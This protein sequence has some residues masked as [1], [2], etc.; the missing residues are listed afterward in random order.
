M[1]SKE[2]IKQYEEI[3]GHSIYGPSGMARI[4]RCPASVSEALRAPLQRSSS[5][6]EHGTKLHNIIAAATEDPPETPTSL[7]SVIS[8]LTRTIRCYCTT[9][10]TTTTASS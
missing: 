9:R 8:T 7:S 5:Y 2:K 10:S 1:L 4:I 3:T 6:A